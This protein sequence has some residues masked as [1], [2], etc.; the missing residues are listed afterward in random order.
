MSAAGMLRCFVG[1]QAGVLLTEGFRSALDDLRESA[2]RSGWRVSWTQPE[3]WHVTLKFLG[4]VDPDRVSEVADRVR[5]A[6]GHV[7]HFVMTATGVAV[8]PPA[9]E[10]RVITAGLRDDGSL[11]R[12]AAAIDDA[13]EPLGFARET[14]RFT[15]HLTLGRVRGAS[16]FGVRKVREVPMG[17]TSAIHAC[18][19][20]LR[21]QRFAEK[22]VGCVELLRSHLAP[23]GSMYTSLESFG[24]AAE[25]AAG[26]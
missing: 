15:P 5:G 22:R 21:D 13:L 14:R 24:L 3:G 2:E 12:L 26:A 25:S 23:G 6:V 4:D 20:R 19:A 10:P 11:A 8:L 1:I 9:G 17:E 7:P 16:R 18:L